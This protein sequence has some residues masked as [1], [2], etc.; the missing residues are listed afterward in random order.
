VQ[1]QVLQALAY[2][3]RALGIWKRVP[4][5]QRALGGQ[6]FNLVSLP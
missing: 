3:A 2:L 4:P 5:L 1:V 6:P